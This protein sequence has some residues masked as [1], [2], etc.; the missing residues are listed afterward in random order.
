MGW[1]SK[2]VKG[3]WSN[4]FDNVK[5]GTK[6]FLEQS[7]NDPFD[8]AGYG[9]SGA[10][11]LKGLAGY[12]VGNYIGGATGMSGWDF[13]KDAGGVA[14]DWYNTTSANQAARNMARDQMAFQERMSSTAYQRA[15]ADMKA[16]GLNPMLAANQGGAS[17]PGGASAP[18]LKQQ[19]FDNVQSALNGQSARQLQRAQSEGALAGADS[20]RASAAKSTA[21]L[22]SVAQS[23]QE[24]IARTDYTR[25]Q[26]A[27][28]AKVAEQ[29]AATIENLQSGTQVNTARAATEKLNQQLREMDLTYYE[30]KIIA[31]AV[32]GLAG[33]MKQF[34]GGKGPRQGKITSP[35]RGNH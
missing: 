32:P 35:P 16:A 25:A 2:L 22:G 21:E 6:N 24:S 8:W 7:W 34:F 10:D 18:V 5:S 20:A 23:I 28:L 14:M 3:D 27:Q 17:T 9:G 33:A 1:L 4:P 30:A 29:I 31:D 12:G 11:I 26:E 19:T 15:M 13:L